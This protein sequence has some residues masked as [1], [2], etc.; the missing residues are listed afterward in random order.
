MHELRLDVRMQLEGL[1]G[2][3]ALVRQGFRVGTAAHGCPAE[4]RSAEIV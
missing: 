3:D 1:C 2:A 4:Q